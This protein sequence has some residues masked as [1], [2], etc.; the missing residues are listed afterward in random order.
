MM[1]NKYIVIIIDVVSV[2]L[3]IIGL[4]A[5]FNGCTN[6]S[7]EYMEFINK[8]GSNTIYFCDEDTGLVIKESITNLATAPTQQI[9]LDGNGSVIYCY[10]DSNSTYMVD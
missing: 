2:L 3:I 6:Q 5:L 4:I 7:Q 1:E 9:A 8:Y 10:N